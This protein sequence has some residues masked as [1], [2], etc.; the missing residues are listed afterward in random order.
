MLE[1]FMK[2]NKTKQENVYRRTVFTS[3]LFT[4]AIIFRDPSSVT[5]TIT[6]RSDGTKISG[7]YYFTTRTLVKLSVTRALDTVNPP[8]TPVRGS[9][10]AMYSPRVTDDSAY[11]HDQP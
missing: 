8:Q 9:E 5:I 2:K 7:D 1:R 6:A 3:G 4:P 10:S 11:Q